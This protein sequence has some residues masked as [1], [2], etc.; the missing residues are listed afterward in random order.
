MLFVWGGSDSDEERVMVP[1]STGCGLARQD[2]GQAG[3]CFSRVRL[4]R[5]AAEATLELVWFV[6][7]ATVTVRLRDR[8]SSAVFS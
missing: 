1:A 4:V 2:P 6:E 5:P 8:T 3:K 7:D